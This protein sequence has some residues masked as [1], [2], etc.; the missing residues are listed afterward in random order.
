MENAVL[1]P[2]NQALARSRAS[3]DPKRRGP[4]NRQGLLN[5]FIAECI[6]QLQ[7]HQKHRISPNVLAQARTGL[8][9]QERF[10]VVRSCF[11]VGNTTLRTNSGCMA[12]AYDAIP[13][14]RHC[15]PHRRDHFAG[16]L[17]NWLP[18]SASCVMFRA[19][20]IPTVCYRGYYASACA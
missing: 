19:S 8:M 2:I 18:I 11:A 4:L 13:D 10:K 7:H 3:H 20:L 6:D 1:D 15:V 5:F 14:A 12:G 17:A 9:G 16:S